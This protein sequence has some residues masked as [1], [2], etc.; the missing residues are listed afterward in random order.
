MKSNQQ[1]ATG[2]LLTQ[3]SDFQKIKPV[4]QGL[5]KF[6]AII[7]FYPGPAIAPGSDQYLKMRQN[8]NGPHELSP[9]DMAGTG[10]GIYIVFKAYS[11]ER[12]YLHLVML[13]LS[14]KEAK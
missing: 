6:P 4:L 7:D 12:C 10:P 11:S 1:L 8:N 14:L 2:N 5:I 9:C 13:K 3:G